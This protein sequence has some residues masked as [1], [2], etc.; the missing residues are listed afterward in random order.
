MVFEIMN[1]LEHVHL[2]QC[3]QVARFRLDTGGGEVGHALLQRVSGVEEPV[4][5][6]DLEQ[7]APQAQ[8]QTPLEEAL[9][10]QIAVAIKALLQAISVI[11][12]V[13]RIEKRYVR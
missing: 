10:E 6:R 12:H 8:Y 4:T 2:S 1:L 3:L 7:S 11:E 9:E 13:T 5:G